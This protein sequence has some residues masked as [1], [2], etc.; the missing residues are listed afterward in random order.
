MFRQFVWEAPDL[1]AVHVDLFCHVYLIVFPLLSAFLNRS[2]PG[3]YESVS[4]MTRT[5]FDDIF[6]SKS[7][8]ASPLECNSGMNKKFWLSS[9]V[10]VTKIT[11]Y[12]ISICYKKRKCIWI[13]FC[14]AI[15]LTGMRSSWALGTFHKCGA[16]WNLKLYLLHLVFGRPLFPHGQYVV[17][18]L[19]CLMV[20][21]ALIN[22]YLLIVS[23]PISN[24]ITNIGWVS[25]SLS[26]RK[27]PAVSDY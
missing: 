10:P 20:N 12:F 13:A 3:K 4:K 21:P 17:C 8:A 26:Y 24:N 22:N 27:K 19:L 14:T 18:H 15:N 6:S 7:S 2:S 11:K 25:I 9:N 16:N 5:D 1:I 23:P